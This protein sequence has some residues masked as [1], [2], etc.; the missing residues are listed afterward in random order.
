[1]RCHPDRRERSD[2]RLNRRDFSFH[3]KWDFC[4]LIYEMR[5]LALGIHP[6]NEYASFQRLS[7]SGFW[8][9]TPK[10]FLRFQGIRSGH[11]KAL[12]TGDASSGREPRGPRFRNAVET[13]KTSCQSLRKSSWPSFSGDWIVSLIIIRTHLPDEPRLT[14]LRLQEKPFI[15]NK[16]IEW[17]IPRD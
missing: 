17:N 13:R 8:R 15:S 4:G 16:E 7:I 12:R 2:G 5:H 1:M 10:G 3:S 9:T 11:F 6:A 14:R